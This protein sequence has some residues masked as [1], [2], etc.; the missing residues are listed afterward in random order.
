MTGS[1]DLA[2]FKLLNFPIAESFV[3]DCNVIIGS[4]T[5]TTP[6]PAPNIRN[7]ALGFNNPS[8]G[9]AIVSVGESLTQTASNNCVLIGSAS[10]VSGDNSTSIGTANSVIGAGS[11]V[12][13][14]NFSITGDNAFAFGRSGL[15]N[16]SN[17]M[18]LGSDGILNIR[19][20]SFSCD[21][22]TTTLPFQTLY[23]KDA[24]ISE[25]LKYSS[26][27]D[28]TVANTAVETTLTSGSSLGNLAYTA[29]LPVGSMIKFHIAINVNSAAG[30]TLT[31]K[32]KS[33]GSDLWSMAIV[34]GV[35]VNSL[36][37]IDITAMVQAANIQFSTLRTVTATPL[38]QFDNA[39]FNPANN[40]TFT[41]T[42]K[43]GLA[44]SSAVFKQVI[45]ESAR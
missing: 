44:A 45:V 32:I 20:N 11:V 42:A 38:V 4:G 5:T 18:V 26:G 2:N 30:D 39:V 23:L 8:E 13:G 16:Q 6:G 43:W 22:G 40:N 34:Y 15:N 21:L 28:I 14:D 24:A 37:I 10:S 36:A 19:P 31:L 7:V 12:I 41:I 17:T 29:T 3:D 1:L 25:A 35:V 9:F 33:N 27:D